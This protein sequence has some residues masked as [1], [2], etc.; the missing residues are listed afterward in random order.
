MTN[1][2]TD[3][4]GFAQPRTVPVYFHENILNGIFHQLPVERKAHTIRKQLI[5]IFFVKICIDPVITREKHF[6]Q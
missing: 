6:P 3:V 1:A 2:A 4:V 5:R